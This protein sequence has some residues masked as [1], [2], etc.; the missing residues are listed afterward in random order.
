MESNNV[1]PVFMAAVLL[2]VFG[3]AGEFLYNQSTAPERQDHAVAEA[4]EWMQAMYPEVPAAQVHVSC[5][6]TDSDNNGY[7]SC[8]VR[9]GETRVNLECYSYIVANPGHSTCREVVIPMTRG[10]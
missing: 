1:L 6:G 9:A 2:G 7:V 3:V 8:S 10:R 5:Q 4:R